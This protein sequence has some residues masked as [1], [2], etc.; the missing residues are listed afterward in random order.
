MKRS[1]AGLGL[2]WIVAG[3]FVFVAV[4]V[5]VG[6]LVA[7]RAPEPPRARITTPPSP[8]AP[9]APAL[10]PELQALAAEIEREDAPTQ[11]L[12]ESARLAL[13]QEQFALAIPAYR[14]VLNRDPK[15]AEALTAMGFILYRANHVEQALARLDE[16]LRAD[17]KYAPAYWH[18]GH[19]L[20]VAKKDVAGARKALESFL[21][22]VPQGQE[23]D[24]AR[25]LLD[26]LGRAGASGG[27]PKP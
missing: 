2:G 26:E 27:A 23:A 14:R 15:N 22:L 16:A 25:A 11:K 20:Y 24:R 5:G 10:S 13:R 21:A 18:R 4:G 1:W 7:R 9:V 8:S 6:L 12:L 3:A 19:M 17:P